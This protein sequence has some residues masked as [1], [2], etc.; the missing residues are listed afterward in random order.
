LCVPSPSA[1]EDARIAPEGYSGGRMANAWPVIGYEG[2]EGKEATGTNVR[3][4][5][6]AALVTRSASK[7]DA[8]SA[9]TAIGSAGGDE[10][11]GGVS[12]ESGSSIRPSEVRRL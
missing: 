9:P 2:R 8:R 10:F 11:D 6:S 4:I 5:A 3:S 12:T 7:A 1:C